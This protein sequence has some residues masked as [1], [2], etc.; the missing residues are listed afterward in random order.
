M[1][2]ACSSEQAFFLRRGPHWTDETET[3]CLPTNLQHLLNT[4]ATCSCFLQ[5]YRVP[6]PVG[7]GQKVSVLLQFSLPTGNLDFSQCAEDMDL[8]TRKWCTAETS[9]SSSSSS[10]TSTSNS[11]SSSSSSSS[12]YSPLLLLL[13]L[14]LFFFFCFFFFFFL[15]FFLFFSFFF[16]FFFFYFF[17]L[18]FF[19]SFFFCWHYSPW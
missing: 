15:S 11:T 16:F 8:T 17:F 2:E 9:S 10:T 4:S 13:L 7:K 19:F 1:H 12:S 3:R 14:F 18:L 6:S 5:I